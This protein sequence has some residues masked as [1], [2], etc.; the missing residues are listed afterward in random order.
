MFV[1]TCRE[2]HPQFSHILWMFGGTN[3]QVCLKM[4]DPQAM[5]TFMGNNAWKRVRNFSTNP[6]CHKHVLK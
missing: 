6:C 3:I 2:N 5:A 4:G 1:G